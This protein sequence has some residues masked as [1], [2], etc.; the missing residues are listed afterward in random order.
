MRKWL[1]SQASKQGKLQDS[2]R[3]AWEHISLQSQGKRARFGS[4]LLAQ[5][6]PVVRRKSL[7]HPQEEAYSRKRAGKLLWD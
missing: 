5:T 4:L 3:R 2:G 7:E 6:Y 1:A